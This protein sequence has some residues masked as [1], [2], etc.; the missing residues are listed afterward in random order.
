MTS[1]KSDFT[2]FAQ[3]NLATV[4]FDVPGITGFAVERF[5]NVVEHE[6]VSGKRLQP[7]QTG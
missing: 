1:L 5:W 2:I 7:E 3:I 4:N 6:R